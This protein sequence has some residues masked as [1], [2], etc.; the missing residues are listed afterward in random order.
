MSRSLHGVVAA[1]LAGC[2][3]LITAWIGTGCISFPTATH[4]QPVNNLDIEKRVAVLPFEARHGN[5]QAMADHFVTE[6]L[7]YGFTVVER[8]VVEGAAKN[9]GIDLSGRVLEPQEMSKLADKSKVDAFVFGTLN[10]E[11]EKQGGLILSVSL[12]MVNAKSGEVILSSSFKNEKELQPYQIPKVMMSHI[13]S[14][15]KKSVKRKA[16]EQKRKERRALEEK[17]RK[18][19]QGKD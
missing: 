5:G 6:F 13:G 8:N 1:V 14:R 15:V 11:P 18:V 2:L 10:A 19:E 9:L 16:K 17:M 7:G 4:V 3:G 12:R